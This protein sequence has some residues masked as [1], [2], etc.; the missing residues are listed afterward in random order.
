MTQKKSKSACPVVFAGLSLV[1]ATALP[2]VAHAD[3]VV[4]GTQQPS[5]P[6]APV[7]VE[8]QQPAPVV[9]QPQAPVA[10]PAPRHTTVI[11]HEPHNYMSTIAW[12]AIAGGVAGVLVGGAIYYLVDDR[13]H[14]DR[15]FYWGAGGVLVGSAVGIMQVVSEENRLDRAT[16]SRLPGDPAPTYRLA[17][18]RVRF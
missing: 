18:Y 7:V 9:A 6:P 15:I 8:P 4:N 10:A 13:A 1:V 16:A 3:V 11:E 2:Q 17:L 5:P 14:A 12:S